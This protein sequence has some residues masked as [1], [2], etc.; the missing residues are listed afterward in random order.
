MRLNYCILY[1]V[2]WPKVCFY[3]ILFIK[4]HTYMLPKTEGPS[5]HFTV[6][7]FHTFINIAVWFDCAHGNGWR[8]THSPSLA[9]W[10]LRLWLCPPFSALQPLLSRDMLSNKTMATTEGVF[11]FIEW[12]ISIFYVRVPAVLCVSTVPLCTCMSGAVAGL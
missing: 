9:I 7:H 3:F 11:I 12:A 10:G 4:N 1:S 6:V 2:R 8:Q 5:S